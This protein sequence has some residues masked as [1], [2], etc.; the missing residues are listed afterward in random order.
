M[1]GNLPSFHVT[2]NRPFLKTSVEYAGP[3]SLKVSPR[4][5]R[6][7][8]KVPRQW[9]WKRSLITPQVPS[10]LQFD[11]LSVIENSAPCC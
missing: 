8:Y 11:N 3:V 4:R 5:G 2:P 10:S 6:A 1:M 7:T 9:T